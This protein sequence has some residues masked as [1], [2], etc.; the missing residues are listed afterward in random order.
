MQNTHQT[1]YQRGE[2]TGFQSQA[3]DYMEQVVDLGAHLDLSRPGVYPVR[4]DGAGFAGR[5]ILSG[6]I[7][8]ADTT[9]TLREDALTVACIGGTVALATLEK[10]K[11]RW[12]L[13][14]AHGVS[15]PVS[16]NAEIWA[17]VTGLVRDRI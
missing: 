11:G 6:D 4:V 7:L 13:R 1:T 9:A 15:V 12:C 16:E 10:S 5:G 3:H 14:R 8:I 17:V 2:T